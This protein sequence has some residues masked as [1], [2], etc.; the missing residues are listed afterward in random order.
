MPARCCVRCKLPGGT[1]VTFGG[2]NVYVAG[3]NAIYRLD[4]ALDLLGFSLLSPSLG[5]ITGIAAGAFGETYVSTAH[6][7]LRLSP[8]R[9]HGRA[10]RSP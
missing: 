4:S 9:P 2:G 7:L 10:E 8:S 3:G 1:D 5:P 6:S